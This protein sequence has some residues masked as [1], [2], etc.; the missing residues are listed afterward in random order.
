MLTVVAA[1]VIGKCIKVFKVRNNNIQNKK[2]NNEMK[3][4]KHTKCEYIMR[5]KNEALTWSTI[6]ILHYYLY[7]CH[8]FS[9]EQ[10]ALKKHF[11]PLVFLFVLIQY[12]QSSSTIR[13]VFI[14]IFQTTSAAEIKKK[15][16]LSTMC[17]RWPPILHSH[18]NLNSC[19][20][21]I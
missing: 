4:F 11:L 5:G 10:K 7:H 6:F 17:L 20:N 8:W 1:F 16:L 15:I 19:G 14:S 13:W 2:A 3:Y 18:T 9:F 21:I 12:N